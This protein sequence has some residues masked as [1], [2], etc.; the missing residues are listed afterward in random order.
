MSGFTVD[1][2]VALKKFNRELDSYRR[3]ESRYR[4]RGWWLLEVAYPTML[5]AMVATKIQPHVVVFGV[6]LDFTDYDFRP[7][8]VTLVNPITKIPYSAEEL[9]T[10]LPRLVEP[11]P[12][13]VAQAAAAGQ[14]VSGGVLQPLMQA[15]PG[16]PPFLCLP[17]VREYHDHPAHSGDLWLLR[18]GSGE[19]RLI[20]LLEQLDRYGTSC[21]VGFQPLMNISLTGMTLMVNPSK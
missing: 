13:H 20:W 9:P 4:A 11:K 6:A 10:N 8:S 1:P 7:P 17:G 18:R 15:H 2:A 21:V 14:D 5:F 19:G 3:E 16:G 12:E